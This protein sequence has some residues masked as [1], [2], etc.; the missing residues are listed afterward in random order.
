[1]GYL[2]K[3]PKRG[4]WINLLLP[5]TPSDYEVIA[6]KEDFGYQCSYFQEEINPRFPTPLSSELEITIF[7]DADHGH[8]KV[9]GISI[10][11]LLGF[12]GSTP[13]I[14][15]SKRQSSIQTSTF[16]DSPR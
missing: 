3:Y 15:S 13:V 9:T 5:N 14:W 8:D 10:T 11:G 7:V 6:I 12:V 1:M 2:H 16:G 4:Y